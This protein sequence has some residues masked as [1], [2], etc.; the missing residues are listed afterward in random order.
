MLSLSSPDASILCFPGG[1]DDS[2][3][4]RD[5]RWY[6]PGEVNFSEARFQGE[7]FPEAE[8]DSESDRE[9]PWEGGVLPAPRRCALP[10]LSFKLN[11]RVSTAS[12]PGALL[13]LDQGVCSEPDSQCFV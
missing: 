12:C 3:G 13:G 9:C 11:L 10:G 5:R 7:S 2:L 8:I 1:A 4:L 6:F